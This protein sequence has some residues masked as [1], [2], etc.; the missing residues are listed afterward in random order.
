MPQ[1]DDEDNSVTVTAA[2]AAAAAA[3]ADAVD[4]GVVK[5]KRRKELVLLRNPGNCRGKLRRFRHKG[6]TVCFL[7]VAVPVREKSIAAGSW[8]GSCNRSL[9][10][11]GPQW[12]AM[13]PPTATRDK[14]G[15]LALVVRGC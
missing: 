9:M 7:G 13:L 11:V 3:A 12:G 1:I 5:H 10:L 15:V 4:I 8:M 14:L 6:F 2:A